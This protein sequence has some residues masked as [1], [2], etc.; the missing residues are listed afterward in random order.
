M[1]NSNFDQTLTVEA[2]E[3]L[4]DVTAGTGDIYKAIA[5]NDRKIANTGLEAGGIL[6]QGGAL[7]ENVT[8][9]VAGVLKF[10][11]GA[12]TTAGKR[13]TV[14]ASGYM[15]HVASGDYTIGRCLATAVASGAIGV[16]FFNFA[17]PTYMGDSGE[18]S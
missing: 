17:T 3:A 5:L 1:A 16:G 14:A 4:D 11:A 13:L 12:A 8:L 18:A 7:G 6:V 15:V 2:A 10:T 9:A